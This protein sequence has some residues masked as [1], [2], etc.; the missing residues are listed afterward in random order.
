ML[1]HCKELM[2]NDIAGL[3]IQLW[4]VTGRRRATPPTSRLERANN[5]NVAIVIEFTTDTGLLHKDRH[6]DGVIDID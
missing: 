3:R 1:D 5:N 6:L 4:I 2:L